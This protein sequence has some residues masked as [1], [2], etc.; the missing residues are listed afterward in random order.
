[1]SQMLSYIAA[2]GG[3]KAGLA[4]VGYEVFGAGGV[5]L[6]ARTTAGVYELGGGCYGV[7]VTLPN[8]AKSIV[9][10][11]GDAS[12]RFATEDLRPDFIQQV[13]TNRR[14][15]NPTNGR[16]EIFERDDATIMVDGDVFEDVAGAT[17]Y[18]ASSQGIDR[19]DRQT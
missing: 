3:D 12:P 11:S 17:A 6:A 16:Q 2:L 18:N 9:W 8:A 13:L 19:A 10:D 4:T 1:M 14:Q 5:S 7:D 15:T